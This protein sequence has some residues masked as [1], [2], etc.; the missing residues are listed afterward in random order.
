M[1]SYAPVLFVY[2]SHLSNQFDGS[3]R[4]TNPDGALSSPEVAILPSTLLAACASMVK[5]RF[6]HVAVRW[7]PRDCPCVVPSILGDLGGTQ[8]DLDPGPGDSRPHG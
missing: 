6:H 1:A 2:P 4:R 5:V 8:L 3:R 7:I